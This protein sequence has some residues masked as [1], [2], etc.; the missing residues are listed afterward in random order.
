MTGRVRGGMKQP[1]AVIAS[2]AKQS[3]S[4]RRHCEPPG[5]ANARPMTGSAKQ[6]ILPRK[7]RMDCFAALA[8]T[9]KRTFAASPRDAPDDRPREAI[10]RPG[11]LCERSE[12]IHLATVRK[13]GLLRCARND[14]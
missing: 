4:P 6:S 9:T 11:R 1:P 14:D 8:K 3:I 2:A 7:A 13:N 5:R 12:A 10:H